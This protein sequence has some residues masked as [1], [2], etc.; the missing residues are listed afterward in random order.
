MLPSCRVP[1]LALGHGVPSSI[2]PYFTRRLSRCLESMEHKSRKQRDGSQMSSLF[3]VKLMGVCV[4]T[5]VSR[6]L[7]NSSS[8]ETCVR[9]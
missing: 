8:G 2:S 3:L 1:A 7:S 5:P 4:F 6:S 9:A